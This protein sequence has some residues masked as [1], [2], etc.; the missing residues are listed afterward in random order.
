MFVWEGKKGT[1]RYIRDKIDVGWIKSLFI[2]WIEF[3][4]SYYGPLIA[5]K[6]QGMCSAGQLMTQNE[7]FLL[8]MTLKVISNDADEILLHP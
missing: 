6:K 2:S 7:R 1:V 8:H 5:D 3:G 4:P